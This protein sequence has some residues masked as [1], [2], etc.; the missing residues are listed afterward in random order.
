MKK[1]KQLTLTYLYFCLFL[2][3]SCIIASGQESDDARMCKVLLGKWAY[4]YGTYDFHKDGTY[5]AVSYIA[6]Q[7]LV[8]VGKWKLENGTL[9]ET[10]NPKAS[11][12]GAHRVSAIKISLLT[13]EKLEGVIQGEK[14]SME[15]YVPPRETRGE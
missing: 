7:M 6:N 8:E 4:T 13:H 12:D 5:K 2:F 3:A 14:I 9:T 10:P 15:R 11:T 1:I